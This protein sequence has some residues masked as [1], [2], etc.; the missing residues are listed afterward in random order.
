MKK[1]LSLVTALA[2][3][4][5]FPMAAMAQTRGNEPLH[6]VNL[7]Q[8]GSETFATD[9][10]FKARWITVTAT[11]GGPA[12]V[13]LKIILEETGKEVY[14]RSYHDVN[15][16][17]TSPE[18]FLEYQKSATVP[19]RVE[20]YVNDELVKNVTIHRMLLE[21]RNNTVT[22]RGIRFREYDSSITDEWMMFTPVDFSTISSDNGAMEIDL[23]GSNMYI[24]GKLTILRNGDRF[25]FTLQNIDEFNATHHISE[26]SFDAEMAAD[27]DAPV[28][29]NHNFKFTDIKI[30]LY[31]SMSAI[32]TVD[33]A[34][35]RNQYNLDQWYSLS[36]S[37]FSNT[38]Q[39][40][41][42]N[43]RVSYDPNGLE[44]IVDNINDSRTGQLLNLLSTFPQV[45]PR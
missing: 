34:E 30:G 44:R 29:E 43:G 1:L 5:T 16:A 40:L 37:V 9:N 32:E 2:V 22:T 19:Y 11:V 24:V 41:Y 27:P 17:F 21:L 35:M 12:A 3:L 26:R 25:M 23:I 7:D 33:H 42:L 10:Y 15:G 4:F 28:I 36:G 18:I 20:L 13:E 8:S 31:S 14:T 38:K 45:E 39:I 6:T